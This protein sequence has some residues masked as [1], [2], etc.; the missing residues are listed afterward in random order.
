MSIKELITTGAIT[1]VIGGT[2]YTINQTDVANNFADDTG[3][4]QQ[5]A[6]NYVNG[7]SED[8]L[9]SYDTLGA[10]YL[11]QGKTLLN[12]T[13]KIDCVNFEYEWESPTLSC[14]A[15]KNQ[16]IET[17]NDT[18]TLG[19]AYIKLSHDSASETDMSTAIKALD[20]LNDSMDLAINQKTLDRATLD[21]IKN[22]NS[23]NKALIETALESK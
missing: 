11:D 5:Q 4:S 23:Y 16:L 20:E 22:T 12:E 2:T 9:V 17:G 19:N 21:D 1:L 18:V 10:D 8:E 15:G 6:E 13:A 14:L 3:M 7:V